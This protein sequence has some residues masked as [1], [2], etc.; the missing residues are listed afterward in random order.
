MKRILVHI[1]IFTTGILS[2]QTNVRGIPLDSLP[3]DLP[4]PTITTLK[5]PADGYI[6][7]AVPYW[8][9]GGSYLVMYNNQ[10]NPV[11]FKRTPPTC[12]DFKLHENGLLT[13][14]DPY[15]KK[16]FA[17]D[18]TFAVIDSFWVQNG[19]TTDEHDIKILKNGNVLLIGYDYKSYD[20]SQIVPG[21]DRN[22]SVIVNVVQ[23]IDRK[24]TVVFEWKAYEHYKLTDV[25]PE[26]N[27]LD[28]SF[29]H[30]HVNS[31][32]VD[33][34]S[35]LVISARNL[36]EITKIDRK[37]GNIIWRL[38]GKNNQFKFIND[39]VGFNAQHD[40]SILTNGHL[41]L[42]DN[43]LFHIPH[44]SRAVEYLLNTTNKTATLVWSYRNIPDIASDIWGNVQRLQNGNTLVGWGNNEVAATE[45]DPMGQKVFE[46]TFPK[47]VF[48]YRVFRFPMNLNSVVSGVR[49][50]AVFTDVDL[51][52]NFPNPFNGSTVISYNIPV[53]SF[54]SLMVYDLLGREVTALVHEEQSVGMHRVLFAPRSLPGGIF[55][56]RMRAGNIAKAGKMLYL[57]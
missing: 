4:L 11:Y 56:Y 36:D 39:T 49:G 17:L 12:T 5:N 32:D 37:S 23:E 7:A 27:L 21:G 50:N 46:M 25:G 51:E 41:I 18:T 2:A 20:M 47:N 33:L 54:V 13:Y 42:F 38:G 29:V 53:M 19:P 6:F 26:V 45:V 8:G 31:I 15:S 22:A 24:K 43:G 57:K 16:F 34:D 55:F 9:T 35:N 52:Q 44:F 14:F 28:P 30:S 3:S 10:G 1:F 48:S 40:A